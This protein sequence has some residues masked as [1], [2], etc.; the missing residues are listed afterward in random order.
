MLREH[1]YFLE[2]TNKTG[3]RPPTL[4]ISPELSIK[5][6]AHAQDTIE[7]SDNLLCLLVRYHWM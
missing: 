7:N 3:M 4:S 6:I 1:L 2:I 5:V